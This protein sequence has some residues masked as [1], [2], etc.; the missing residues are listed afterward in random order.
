MDI[1]ILKYFLAVAHEENITKAS[2]LLHISQPS[3]SKQMKELE[4]E[5][6][7]QLFIRG[8]R[9]TTLTE[10]GK[11]LRKRAEELITLFDKTQQELSF[12][13]SFMSGT[14]S[15]GGGYSK[16][17]T[18]TVSKLHSQFPNIHF[19]F[20]NG[21]A[22]DVEEKLDNGT[23]DFGVLID[24]VDIIKYDYMPLPTKDTWGF[25]MRKDFPLSKKEFIKPY[26]IKNVPLIIHKRQVLQRELSLW[27]GIDIEKLN[28]VA[29]YNVF[30]NNPVY[31]VKNGIGCA[32]VSSQ[33]VDWQEDDNICFRPIYP[34]SEIQLDIVWKRHQVFSKAANHF[35]K[36][37]RKEIS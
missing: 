34:L 20:Y 28:V 15:I 29:T 23:L 30:F 12:N 7:K 31:L 13:D 19:D 33:S 37:L 8:K 6:G 24:P 16:I 5:F 36:I 17:I 3:L 32:F 35:L 11:F 25:L 27:S 9:K 21:D 2:E 14:I 10:D 18:Q 4:N 22:I 26:D 1:R